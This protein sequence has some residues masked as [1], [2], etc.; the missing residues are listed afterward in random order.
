MASVLDG[1]AAQLAELQRYKALYGE[2]TDR[3]V[4]DLTGSETE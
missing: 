3:D 2:I 1:V 4:E